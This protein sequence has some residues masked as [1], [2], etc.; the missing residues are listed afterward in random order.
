MS[1]KLYT[2]I[3]KLSKSTCTGVRTKFV[4]GRGK[5]SQYIISTKICKLRKKIH[6]SG[7]SDGIIMEYPE[8]E[9][10]IDGVGK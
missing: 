3:D 4:F 1:F 2:W 9:K 7:R 10:R 6:D 8:R 5:N